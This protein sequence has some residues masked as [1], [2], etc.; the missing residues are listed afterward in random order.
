MS[1]DELTDAVKAA[2]AEVLQRALPAVDGHT[3]LFEDLH[4]DSTSV[5]ELLMALEDSVGLVVDPEQLRPEDFQTIGSLVDYASAQ[6]TEPV[7][8]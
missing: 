7:L 2:L 8:G 3:R 4:L 6:L 5:L 1:R